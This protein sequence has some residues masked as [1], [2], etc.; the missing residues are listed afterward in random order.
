[1]H[2]G[3]NRHKKA[4]RRQVPRAIRL[5][6][7]FAVVGILAG[8][9]DRVAYLAYV[10][11]HDVGLFEIV[12]PVVFWSYVKSFPGNILT[13]LFFGSWVVALICLRIPDKSDRAT[14]RITEDKRA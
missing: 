5:F 9:A 11:K 6:V 3:H 14:D 8:I 13:G 12:P 2:K 7:F 1:M 4:H 10:L